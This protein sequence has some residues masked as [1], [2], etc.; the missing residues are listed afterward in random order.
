MPN[1]ASVLKTEISRLAR[2]ELRSQTED[3]RKTVAALRADVAA[4]KKQVRVLEGQSRR[5]GRSVERTQA[6][7]APRAGLNGSAGSADKSGF[8]FTAK[9]LASNRKRLAL[10][11][12]AFGQLV[13]VSGQSV[14]TWERSL[15]R[16]HER[17]LPA[18]AELRGIGKREVTRRLEALATAK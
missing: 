12:D 6:A 7:V 17:H 14:Y 13:G 8:R 2:K 3:L 10:S 11:A 18:I 4:L 16:P 9:G 1:I 15:G 5:L